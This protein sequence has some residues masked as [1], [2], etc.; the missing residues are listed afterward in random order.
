MATE[1]SQYLIQTGPLEPTLSSLLDRVQKRTDVE[2]DLRR[3]ARLRI[4]ERGGTVYVPPMAKANILASNDVLFS[5][6]LMAFDWM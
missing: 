4:K 1:P 6:W 5:L 2:A 3:I